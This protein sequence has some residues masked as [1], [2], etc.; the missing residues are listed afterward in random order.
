MAGRKDV[1]EIA[2]RVTR[3][4]FFDCRC[5]SLCLS[6]V[7]ISPA[8]SP[9]TVSSRCVACK[10]RTLLCVLRR[11]RRRRPAARSE[12][13]VML[14]CAGP[15]EPHRARKRAPWETWRVQCLVADHVSGHDSGSV[16]DKHPHLSLSSARPTPSMTLLGRHS[17]SAST[18]NTNLLRPSIR[19][20]SPLVRRAFSCSARR[21]STA[22]TVELT[23]VSPHPVPNLT[24]ARNVHLAFQRHLLQPVLRR[25]A[26][27]AHTP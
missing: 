24:P 5:L 22:E 20:P 18:M 17:S 14:C 6:L 7:C 19:I 3:C 27:A 16:S 13:G 2:R 15:A 1:V 9:L 26:P 10:S 11:K 8:P 12:P 25:L 23:S 21:L 4:C